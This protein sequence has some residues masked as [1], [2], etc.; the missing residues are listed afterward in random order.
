MPCAIVYAMRILGIDYGKRRV[1]LAL[2]DESQ[3]MAMPYAIFANDGNLLS[4]VLEVIKKEA[5]AKAVMGEARDYAGAKNPIM[6]EAEEFK[7]SLEKSAGFVV[8]LEPEFMTSALAA[9]RPGKFPKTRAP[10]KREPLDAKAAAIILQSFLDKN[11][12]G[13]G[14]EKSEDA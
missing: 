7:R 10:Q 1:G 12:K 8:A 3:K 4:R 11:K 14:K 2:S 9:R 6:E 5:V 13:N